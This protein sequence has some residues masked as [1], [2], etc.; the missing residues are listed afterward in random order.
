LLNHKRRQ[1]PGLIAI[2]ALAVTGSYPMSARAQTPYPSKPVKLIVPFP[3]GGG[4][5]LIARLVAERLTNRFS[6]QFVVDNRG[7]AA[8]NIGAAAVAKAAADGYTLLVTPQS[9]LTISEFLKPAPQFNAARDLVPVAIIAQTKLVV[10]VNSAVPAKTLGEFI[11]LAKASPGK[12]FFGSAGTGHETHLA[13]ELLKLR[14]GIDIRHVPFRGVGPALNDLLAGHVHMLAISV[15]GNIAQH[16]AAGKLR[17]LAAVGSERSAAFPNV[18]S[19]TEGGVE[20]DAAPPWF[21]VVAPAKTPPEIIEQLNLEMKN[22]VQDHVYQRAVAEVGLEPAYMT[23][24]QSVAYVEKG[25]KMWGDLV[26][27]TNLALTVE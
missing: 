23:S 13:V 14:T 6:Q 20:W 8:G 10:I 25:R 2:A 3:A 12:Y 26:S 17:V 27:R 15:A 16:V 11:S 19:S 9:P 18:P 21:A 1:M 22:L 7:G 4:T 5:D 24:A